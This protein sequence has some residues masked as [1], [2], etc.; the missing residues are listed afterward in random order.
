MKVWL[1]NEMHGVL[2]LIANFLFLNLIWLFIEK[3]M[4]GEPKPNTEDSIMLFIFSLMYTMEVFR[5]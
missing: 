2:T 5:K 1:N 3:L 4:Y